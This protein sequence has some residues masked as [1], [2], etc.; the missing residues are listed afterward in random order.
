MSNRVL[1]EKIKTEMVKSKCLLYYS[2]LLLND[3]TARR[4][5]ETLPYSFGVT[6]HGPDAIIISVAAVWMPLQIYII[7]SIGLARNQLHIRS[8]LNLIT[9]K[10]VWYIRFRLLEINHNPLTRFAILWLIIATYNR[11]DN[12]TNKIFV[13]IYQ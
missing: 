4:D 7:T 3:A 1:F 10:I 8:D 6:F 11:L 9:T 12:G 2:D 5:N 13:S